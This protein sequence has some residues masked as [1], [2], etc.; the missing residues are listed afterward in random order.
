MQRPV[1]VGFGGTASSGVAGFNVYRGPDG[2]T[3][4]KINPGLVPSTLYSDSTVANTST[5]YYATTAVDVYGHESDKSA[6][7]EAVIP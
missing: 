1:S 3:W 2:V 6:A 7:V 4:K 5:Y